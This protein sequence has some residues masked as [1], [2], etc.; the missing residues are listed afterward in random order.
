MGCIKKLVV[1][2]FCVAA[3]AF[4]A[5]MNGGI[6]LTSSP[7]LTTRSNVALNPTYADQPIDSTY[8][9]GPGDYL[10]LVLENNYLSVQIYPDGSV[11]I[12]ECGSVN[13]NGKTI[14]EAR[15]LIL[16]LAAK[17]YKKELCFVQLSVLKKFRINIMG[18]VSQVGQHTVE[19]QTRLSYFIRQVGGILPNANTED[20]WLM[21]DGDTLH[22][23][24]NS[25]SSKGDFE[26]DVVLR[27]GDKIYVP[28]VE[29]KD[30]VV[31]IFPD[32]RANVTYKEG[33]TLQEYYD[34][35]GGNRMSAA[36]FKSICVREPGKTP[37]WVTMTEMKEVKVAANTEVEFLV[38]E[39]K[40]Y[41][42]GA[43]AAIG[44]FP[45]NPSWHAI[46]YIGAAGIN[47]I[48][49]SWDQVKV[50]RGSEPKAVS[51]KVAED[52]ILPGDL[53]EIPRSRYESVKDFT[54]FLASLLTVI[55]S[56]LI[57]YMTIK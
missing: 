9:L 26:T 43:V 31:M 23:D 4:A 15:E 34:L 3:V 41:V 11:T 29:V 18:A 38:Q 27:Q 19:P 52:E 25:M 37:R 44:T 10:D 17:R 2:F 50:W 6:E 16:D 28:F 32:S 56:A 5:S 12:E 47:I 39:Q 1:F 45:Y 40:V 35:A 33:K 8:K 51:V 24:Y 55:S 13:V 57:L 53:I 21:R 54:L 20:I 42:G 46:D 14:S 48:T 49:G 22:I 7:T 36:S 30:N